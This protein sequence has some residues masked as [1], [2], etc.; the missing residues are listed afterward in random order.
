MQDTTREIIALLT[1]FLNI[2]K[3]NGMT[4][5]DVVDAVRKIAGQRQVGHTGTLDPF[6][7]GVLVLALGRAT[8]LASH[9]QSADKAYEGVIRLGQATDT[10]DCEGKVTEEHSVDH[11]DEDGIRAAMGMLVGD[12]QQ[13]PPPFSAKKVAG[14]KLYEYARKGET[15]EVEPKD[16]TVREFSLLEWSPPEARFRTVVTTG[17]YARSLAHDVGQTLGCGGHLNRLVRTQVGRF[18]IEEALTLDAL[19]DDPDLLGDSLIPIP[20][21]IPDIPTLIISQEAVRRIANGAPAA[22]ELRGLTQDQLE[23]DLLFAL[24]PE[25]HLVAL[26]EKLPASAGAIRYQP[27]IQLAQR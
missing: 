5:H 21:A 8:K 3:P 15:V 6:A 19:R 7:T 20:A 25:G 12:I 16:V 24:D 17:T 1:G 27:K 18:R 2:N 14:K 26:V 22:T 23:A 4:S 10:Y 11:L 13:V 9:V